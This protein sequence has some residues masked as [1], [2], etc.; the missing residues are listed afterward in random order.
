MPYERIGD[1]NPDGIPNDF[2]SPVRIEL[3]SHHSQVTALDVHALQHRKRVRN[4]PSPIAEL[5][6]YG[7][8]RATLRDVRDGSL[9]PQPCQILRA[10]GGKFRLSAR[11]ISN[12]CRIKTHQSSY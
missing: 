10:L 11:K 6:H 9:G 4:L 2:V 12:S 1:E 7:A 8:S 3:S 5:T